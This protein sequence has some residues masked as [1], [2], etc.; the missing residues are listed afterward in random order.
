MYELKKPKI[1]IPLFCYLLHDEEL[2]EKKEN[3][4]EAFGLQGDENICEIIRSF[5]AMEYKS[6]VAALPSRNARLVPCSDVDKALFGC[7]SAMYL[8]GSKTDAKVVIIYLCPYLTKRQVN[9]E[10]SLTTHLA[11]L[12]RCIKYP[13]I[14]EDSNTNERKALLFLQRS[15]HNLSGKEE[16]HPGQAAA[17][18][19]NMDFNMS[20]HKYSYLDPWGI[21]SFYDDTLYNMS[22]DEEKDHDTGDGYED[23]D[24]ENQHDDHDHDDDDDDDDDN[25]DDDDVDVGASTNKN[26][27]MD[28]EQKS[29]SNWRT[30]EVGEGD[31]TKKVSM[32]W[33]QMYNDRPLELDHIAPY[34][35]EGICEVIQIRQKTPN[36]QNTCIDS[37]DDND[38]IEV[39]N[40]KKGSKMGRKRTKCY[41]FKKESVLYGYYSI[42]LR[43]KQV[44]PRLFFPNSPQW[45][46]RV[47]AKKKVTI[48]RYLLSLFSPS[49]RKTNL[50][51]DGYSWDAFLEFCQKLITCR[52]GQ[53]LP[54]FYNYT[55]Y[56]IMW[57]IVDGVKNISPGLKKIHIMYRY[58][59]RT[60]WPVPQTDIG[61]DGIWH[62]SGTNGLVDINRDVDL[63]RSEASKKSSSSKGQRNTSSPTDDKDAED[64][65]LTEAELAALEK[66]IAR[67]M[68]ALDPRDSKNGETNALIFD[69][70]LQEISKAAKEINNLEDS[71][72][73]ANSINKDVKLNISSNRSMMALTVDK[74]EAMA[75]IKK[76]VEYSGNLDEDGEITIGDA[77][78]ISNVV[79]A[80]PEGLPEFFPN[81]KG[82]SHQIYFF[83]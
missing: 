73:V 43:S 78:D 17:F 67:E 71:A 57:N 8:L 61:T 31:S 22:I 46:R 32:T 13:S 2:E 18:A 69:L 21:M 83:I 74:K 15:C 5:T 1:S 19:I 55:I 25:D 30:Y 40:V 23:A 75:H 60:M 33:F 4:I 53:R 62:F 51:K 64:T 34:I 49:D 9:L 50:P 47:S 14:A 42:R 27:P 36:Q 65:F 82:V 37:E 70:F 28:Y 80:A 39:D 29:K 3:F 72:L 79:P 16:L 10:I 41:D 26:G 68:R 56:K 20:S 59:N 77:T 6:L 24:G 48:A 38:D 63:K 58:S 45:K 35:F 52:D 54:D 12:E 76:Y 11:T 81:L 66:S 44:I 7:N